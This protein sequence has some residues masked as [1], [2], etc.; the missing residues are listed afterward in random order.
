MISMMNN[1]NILKIINNNKQMELMWNNYKKKNNNI[2]INVLVHLELVD[3][4]NIN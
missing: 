2:N 3:F 4:Y 1:K